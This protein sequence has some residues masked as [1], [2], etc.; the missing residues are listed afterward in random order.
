MKKQ[1][2][3]VLLMVL[4][5]SCFITACKNKEE[6]NSEEVSRV[7]QGVQITDEGM[8]YID[9]YTEMMKF[10]DFGLKTVIPLCDRPNCQHNSTECNAY[11]K[12]LAWSIMGYHDGQVYY[13]DASDV[14]LPLYVCDKNGANR[15]VLVKLNTNPQEYTCFIATCAIFAKNQLYMAVQY[16]PYAKTLTGELNK[17][18]NIYDSQILKID[19]KNGEIQIV[20]ELKSRPMSPHSLVLNEYKDE[21]LRYYDGETKKEYLLDLNTLEERVIYDYNAVDAQCVEFAE[22]LNTAYYVKWE[23]DMDRI[24]AYDL[25]TREETC[26]IELEKKEEFPVMV[27]KEG[28][29]YYGYFDNDGLWEEGTFGKYDIKEQAHK[30]IS[31]EEFWYVS[32][33]GRVSENWY[34]RWYPPKY[35]FISKEDYEKQN[36]DAVQVLDEY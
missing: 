25:N 6:E 2:I 17:D 36:W 19:L 15:K 29:L 1:S 26:L 8:F 28:T 3:K 5:F 12:D 16:D 9:G 11:V 34:C 33:T 35:Y 10:Y 31:K 32:D 30:E 13:I 21:M 18:A 22:D 24:Y 23:G 14:E 20:K 27:K 4:L 7:S